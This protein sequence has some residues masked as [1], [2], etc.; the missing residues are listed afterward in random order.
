[1]IFAETK[2]RQSPRHS[3]ETQ[4]QPA[5]QWLGVVLDDPVNLMS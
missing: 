3:T 1:M 2:T 4:E 5:D